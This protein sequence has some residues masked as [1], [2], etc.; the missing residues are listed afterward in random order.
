MSKFIFNSSQYSLCDQYLTRIWWTSAKTQA[1]CGWTA[2]QSVRHNSRGGWGKTYSISS[3]NNRKGDFLCDQ[4]C[5]WWGVILYSWDN[6]TIHSSLK[7]AKKWVVS[8]QRMQCNWTSETSN[9]CGLNTMIRPYQV[10]TGA[11][12]YDVTVKYGILVEVIE[13]VSEVRVWDFYVEDLKGI[14]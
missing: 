1:H 13:P 4:G 9:Y 5:R 8:K 10:P 3:C 11:D 2:F 6:C 14:S 12:A 7:V